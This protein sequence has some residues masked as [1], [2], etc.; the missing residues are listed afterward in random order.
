MGEIIKNVCIVRKPSNL[1]EVFDVARNR[2]VEELETVEVV[3]TFP[4]MEAEYNMF[5]TH[6]LDS[7][8]FLKGNL[9]GFNG[10]GIRQVIKI[11]ANYKPTIYVDPSGS[12][13]GRYVGIEVQIR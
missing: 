8:G 7:Y 9:G 3:K 2:P 4:L 6:P 5:A 1:E 13:Y 10:D 12:N 11:T